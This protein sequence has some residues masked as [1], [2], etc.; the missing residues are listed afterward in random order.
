MYLL[1]SIPHTVTLFAPPFA[2]VFMRISLWLPFEIACRFH[3]LAILIIWCMPESLKYQ[4]AAAELL[5]VFPPEVM[6]EVLN[7]IESSHSVAEHDETASLLSQDHSA[8]LPTEK[9]Y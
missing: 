8:L 5:A 7:E 3:V 2:N 1:S 4:K 9:G 6:L